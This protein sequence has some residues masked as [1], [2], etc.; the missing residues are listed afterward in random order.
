MGSIAVKRCLLGAGLLAWAVAAAGAW[1]SAPLGALPWLAVAAWLAFGVAFA[2][3]VLAPASHPAGRALD[4]GLV[5]VVLAVQALA[6][7]VLE[8]S[9][10]APFAGM[11]LVVIAGE[12]G[13]VAGAR[14]A[15]LW[16]GLQSTLFFFAL[17]RWQPY[18]ATAFDVASWIAA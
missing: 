17:G 2:V 11:L 14:T 7:L 12:L 13:L 16:I 3:L 5:R 8:L 10:R 4:S 9:L 18:A 1:R 6:A 15:G